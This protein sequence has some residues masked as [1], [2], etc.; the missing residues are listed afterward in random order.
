MLFPYDRPASA[1]EVLDAGFLLFRR[2]L[3]A[4]LPW[5][6]LAVLLGN[7][8]SV[9][10]LA[11]GQSLSLLERK[12][13]AWW[14]LMG[15]AAVAGLWVWLFLMLRQYRIARGERPGLFGGAGEAMRLVPRATGI[16]LLAALALLL[17]TLL[18]LVPGMY[19]SVAFWPGLTVLVAEGRGVAG[20]LDRAL[21]LVRRSWWH[22]ATVLGV[23][24]GVVMALYVVGVL[25]GLLFAQF[26]GGID[27]SSAT[28]VVGVVSGLLAAAFQ[29]L[30]IAL[31]VAQY[32][33]L[34][35]RE[36]ARSAAPA[37]RS[38]APAAPRL[39]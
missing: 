2:T 29:P 15:G 33:D 37:T 34:L 11:T 8:P 36:A 4:C 22:T 24:G 17:G 5:S 35:R 13:A 18:L 12:D 20:S 32:L 31:G 21:Q 30:F 6:L 1:G 7:L 38:A 10:L 14:G 39:S 26:D 16:I 3:P 25:V 27:R 28:L 23:A 19:L 9:Y